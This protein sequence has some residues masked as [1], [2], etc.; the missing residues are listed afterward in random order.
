MIPYMCRPQCWYGRACS[1]WYRF[2]ELC[3]FVSDYVM[4][5]RVD[6]KEGHDYKVLP[7]ESV[8]KQ[9]HCH[10]YVEVAV[11]SKEERGKG[12]TKNQMVEIK[13]GRIQR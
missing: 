3:F 6:L 5:R 8:A 2:C 4:C 11:Q 10:Q 13:R 12:E 9:H 1:L 7:G